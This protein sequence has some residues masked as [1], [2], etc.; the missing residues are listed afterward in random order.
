M[1]QSLSKS[2]DYLKAQTLNHPCIKWENDSN[3]SQKILDQN[4]DIGVDIA[5]IK[6]L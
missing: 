2:Y 1:L 6:F 4:P 5:S 3:W